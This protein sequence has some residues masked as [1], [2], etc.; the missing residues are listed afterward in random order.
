MTKL[1]TATAALQLADRGQL[2]LDGPAANLVPDFP[3][4]GGGSRVTIR[5][6]LSHS[7]GLA[8]PIPIGW[9]RHAD[10]RQRT[11]TPSL[12]AC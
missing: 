6:L 9:V 11:F 7:A 1:V 4:R 2:D 5:H 8:N 12:P 3:G 10:A